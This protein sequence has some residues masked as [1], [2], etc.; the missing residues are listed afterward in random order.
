MPDTH[1]L[2]VFPKCKVRIDGWSRRFKQVRLLL[3]PTG[4]MELLTQEIV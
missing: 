4:D 2:E 1:E 3:L